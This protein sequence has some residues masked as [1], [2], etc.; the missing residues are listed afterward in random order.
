MNATLVFF[1]FLGFDAAAEVKNPKKIFKRSY[2]FPLL[3]PTLLY[4]VVTL[5]LTGIVPFTD[6]RVKDPVALC[7][8]FINHGTNR[9]NH[10]IGAI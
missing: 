7:D 1:A 4:I 5:V 3:F 2:W 9:D 8:A 10:S 6:F